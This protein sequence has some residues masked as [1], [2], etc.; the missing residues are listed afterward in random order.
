MM[1]KIYYIF[2]DQ[3]ITCFDV[4]CLVEPNPEFCCDKPHMVFGGGE[5]V[6]C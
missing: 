1:L 2:I 5:S 3:G 4:A 6:K